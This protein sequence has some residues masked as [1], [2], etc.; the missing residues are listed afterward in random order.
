MGIFEVLLLIEVI[1]MLLLTIA[2]C[3]LMLWFLVEDLLESGLFKK[4]NK[5]DKK[6]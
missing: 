4:R 6:Y 1:M 5:E 2:A 3:A